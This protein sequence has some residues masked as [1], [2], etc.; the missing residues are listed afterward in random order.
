MV[1]KNS[2]IKFLEDTLL[3]TTLVRVLLFFF[4]KTFLFKLEKE[5]TK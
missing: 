5:K 2:M 3:T 1:G 4:L